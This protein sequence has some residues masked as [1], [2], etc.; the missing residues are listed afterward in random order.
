VVPETPMEVTR[1]CFQDRKVPSL[2]HRSRKGHAGSSQLKCDREG[3]WR[4]GPSGYT[5]QFIQI[6]VTRSDYWPRTFAHVFFP[7]IS[8]KRRIEHILV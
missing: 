8:G 1:V 6:R 5:S 4:Q 2:S 7:A 3:A